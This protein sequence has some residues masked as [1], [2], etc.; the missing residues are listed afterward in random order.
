MSDETF[1]ATLRV[2]NPDREPATLI[3]IRRGLGRTAHV[4][5]TFDGGWKSTAVM[6]QR[7]TT[8]LVDLLSAATA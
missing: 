7:E 8:Q 1:R 4:W 3:V 6:D 2:R 5:L